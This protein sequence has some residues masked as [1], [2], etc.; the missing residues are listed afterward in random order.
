MFWSRRVILFVCY[1]VFNSSLIL[2]NFFQV[3]AITKVW[4]SII[5]EYNIFCIDILKKKSAF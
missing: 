4:L 1:Q 5:F 3:K 2:A